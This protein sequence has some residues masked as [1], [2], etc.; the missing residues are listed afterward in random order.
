[1]GSPVGDVGMK[2]SVSARL[3]AL[4]FKLAQP[5]AS[6]QSRLLGGGPRREGLLRKK[7]ESLPPIAS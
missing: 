3:V 5:P 1:M 4:D 7:S 6:G 2:G